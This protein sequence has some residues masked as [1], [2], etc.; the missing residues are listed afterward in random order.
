MCQTER[1]Y[2]SVSCLLWQSHIVS[3]RHRR[4]FS[5]QM[6]LLGCMDRLCRKNCM[7][8]HQLLPCLLRCKMTMDRTLGATF[9]SLQAIL[10]QSGVARTNKHTTTGR[11]YSAQAEL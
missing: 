11:S 2:Y 1:V 4:Q 3:W 5:R 7:L 6:R 8:C 9:D 10:S